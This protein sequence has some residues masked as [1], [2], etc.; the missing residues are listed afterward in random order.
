MAAGSI[1][2]KRDMTAVEGGVGDDSELSAG[3]TALATVGSPGF[4]GF[5]AQTFLE[6]S[7]MPL[8]ALAGLA[9]REGQNTSPLY[10]VHRW[11]A[12]RLG[13]QFR[14]ILAALT[15]GEDEGARFW[16]RYFGDIP[17]DGALVLD[18]FVGGGTALVEASRCDA[19]VVGYDIDPIAAAITRFELALAGFDDVS[20]DATSLCA[21]LTQEMAPWHTTTLSDGR[22][23]TVLHH[24]WVEIVTC[25][26]CARTFEGHPHHQLAHDK[27]KGIQWG[28][29]GACHTVAELPFADEVFACACGAST[30]MRTGHIAAGKVSC[31]HCGVTDDLA[32]RGSEPA[33]RP[34]WR[35]FAQE[36][37]DFAP[38][39]VTRH[40]KTATDADRARFDGATR[41]LASTEATD[42]RFAPGRPIP[43]RGRSDARPLNHGFRQYRDLFNDRQLLHLTTLGR[44]IAALPDGGDRRMLA[45]AYSDHLAANCM[46]AGYAFGY[47]RLSPLFS[48]HGW[49]HI[50]RPVEL[51]PWLARIGRGTFPNALAKI[52]RARTFAIAPDDLD[53]DG[54]RRQATRPV[55]PRDGH[56]GEAASDLVAGHRRAAI[57]TG[58]S[59]DLGPLPDGSVDLIVTDPPYFDNINYSEMSDFYLA[60]HQSLGIASAPY[61]DPKRAAPLLENLATVSRSDGATAL[62]QE[63]LTA[64]FGECRRVL[65]PDG[66]CVF[67]YHH[68][69]S[70]AWLALGEALA[71]TAL[72]CTAVLPFRGEGQGGLHSEAGTIKWDA[73]LVCRP[74]PAA[75][76]GVDDPVTV[77]PD[78]LDRA[79]AAMRQAVARLG[80]DERLGFRAP[81]ALNLLR[82]L[83]VAA[84]T[85]SA[86]PLAGTGR[87]TAPSLRDALAQTAKRALAPE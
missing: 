50:T 51:N 73:L 48:I 8:E 72:T 70:R 63:R 64:I 81:D 23:A 12:R 22:D 71:R 17:L 10:R 45:I 52:R 77:P 46:Y 68:K 41:A 37:L 21:R 83:V 79:A 1:R 2:V 26:H 87:A 42:G 3:G 18:P 15:L 43:N 53:P 75:A 25:R 27:A 54:Q 32:P 40:F 38:R 29:C 20:P 65:H 49:R 35:L 78:S 62:Y 16:E 24:F 61:D 4:A 58:S 80:P 9:L 28:F 5:A 60:W 30:A 66:V 84:A 74:A 86:T 7:G 85:T 14:G 76:A 39:R 55:G 11:F 56:V 47:R 44:A 36:Y 6:T 19:R 67:T 57:Q 82:A 69:T 31:P 59:T 13:S 33:T 34:T